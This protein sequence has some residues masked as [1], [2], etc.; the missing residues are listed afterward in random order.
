MHVVRD[1]WGGGGGGGVEDDAVPC[2]EEVGA[3]VHPS[4]VCVYVFEREMWEL[5][6]LHT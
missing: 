5:C 6:V 2:S 4:L 3:S 1:E